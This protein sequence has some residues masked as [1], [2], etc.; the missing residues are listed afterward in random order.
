MT[1]TGARSEQ[2][3]PPRSTVPFNGS[4]SR[5]APRGA[6]TSILTRATPARFDA[7]LTIRYLYTRYS[8]L[9]ATAVTSTDTLSSKAGLDCPP[10]LL[11]ASTTTTAAPTASL[12]VSTCVQQAWRDRKS[13]RLNSSHDQISYAVFCLQQHKAP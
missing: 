1:P 9:S 12:W 11:D 5:P 2:S 7:G 4:M 13:T 3:P 10:S 8:E 6:D